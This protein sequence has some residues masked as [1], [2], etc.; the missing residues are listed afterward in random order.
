MEMNPD[1]PNTMT[2]TTMRGTTPASRPALG[3]KPASGTEGVAGYTP[4]LENGLDLGRAFHSE[5][6]IPLK[7][8]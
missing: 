4:A 8:Y 3:F 5:V 1:A 2:M 6:L 7:A